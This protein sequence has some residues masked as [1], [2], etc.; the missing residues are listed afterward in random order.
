S[1]SKLLN[2]KPTLFGKRQSTHYIYLY[3]DPQG[4]FYPLLPATVVIQ[5]PEQ[6]LQLQ[7]L[8]ATQPLTSSIELSSSG[9]TMFSGLSMSSTT[10]STLSSTITTH[11][12]SEN[13][14]KLSYTGS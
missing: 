4:R 8:V 12:S 14:S 5:N 2:I 13:S 10:S 1:L 6:I 7:K 3:Q 11:S 9:S